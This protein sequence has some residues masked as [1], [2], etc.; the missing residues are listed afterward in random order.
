MR[1]VFGLLGLVVV[2]LVVMSLTKKQLQAVVPGAGQSAPGAAAP[3]VPEQSRQMQQ[4]AVQGVERALEQG[5]ARA[6]AATP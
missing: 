6:S 3:T 5:A 1:I 2:L 4:R